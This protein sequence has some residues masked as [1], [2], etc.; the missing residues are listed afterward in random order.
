MALAPS[1]WEVAGEK[2]HPPRWVRHQLIRYH[3]YRY[4]DQ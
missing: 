1:R 3:E 2:L 4:D